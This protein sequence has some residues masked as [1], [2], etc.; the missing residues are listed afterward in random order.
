MIPIVYC[1]GEEREGYT[2]EGIN[3]YADRAHTA[4]VA[5]GDAIGAEVIV[6]DTYGY[7]FLGLANQ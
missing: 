7:A 2:H 3:L 6:D 1:G 5:F 4:P